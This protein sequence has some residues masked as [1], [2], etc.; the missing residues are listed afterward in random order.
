MKI[1]IGSLPDGVHGYRFSE[2]P[3][4]IGLSE[5]D[6][7]FSK[8]DVEATLEKRNRQI[9]LKASVR[10]TKQCTC[11]RCLDEFTQ[12]LSN[13]YEMLYLFD[14]TSSLDFQGDVTIIS[15]DTTEIDID[16]DVRQIALLA[17]PMK[18][19]CRKDCAGLC[20][21]CGKNLNFESCECK[22]AEPDGRWA[23]LAKFGAM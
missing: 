23:A 19:L 22:I 5:S 3:L 4:L 2:Y 17:L 8:V 13:S 10:T 12:V 18:T 9:Y 6:N 1:K 7:F 16:D 21:I 15:P 20:P 14:T 11:D